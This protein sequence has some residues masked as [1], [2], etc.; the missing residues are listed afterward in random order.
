MAL[1]DEDLREAASHRGL[2]LIK[3]RRRKPGVGDFGL[4]GLA[5]ASGK[6]LFGVDDNGLTATADQIADFLRKGEVSTWAASA[7]GTPAR[8]KPEPSRDAPPADEDTASAIRPR[9]RTSSRASTGQGTQRTLP[10]DVEPVEPARAKRQGSEKRL[11]R[12]RA[13]EPELEPK[14]V[15]EP[16]LAIRFARPA[17]A[18]ALR[19]L[20]ASV[21]FDRSAA[22]MKR[23]ITA[24]ATRKE[25][26][27]VADSGGVVGCLAWHIVP[28]I[29]GAG[30]ARITMIA[31]DEDNR[32][33][34]IGR[35][36]YE[37]AL[38]EF[39]KRKVQAV[40]AMSDIEVRNANGFYRA[41]GLKQASYR[42]A[43]DT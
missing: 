40:E 22:D 9:W 7:K 41:L 28:T 14:A 19:N 31:V 4:F 26:I 38:S 27:W 11:T 12:Q 18:D 17:D 35:A 23:V 20:L 30:M 32:R 39:R 36:L 2:K 43:A 15:P 42:F 29:Q 34:G 10:A 21:G 8:S 24:A 6:S 25:P 33:R 3:S 16:E 1:T 13:P 37:M 5:D